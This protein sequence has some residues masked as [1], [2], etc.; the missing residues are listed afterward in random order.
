MLNFVVCDD[1][2]SVLDRL[3]KMLEAIFINNNIDAKIGLQ[4]SIPHDVINYLEHNKVDVLILDINLKS[5]ITG[6][7]IANLL[8]KKNKRL[9]T[10]YQN[11][12]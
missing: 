10:I 5:E 3:C 11:L 9:L 4:S 7:D 6:C 8:R 1:N 2:L 12:L